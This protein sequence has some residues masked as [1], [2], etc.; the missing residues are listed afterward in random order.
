MSSEP[1]TGPDLVWF[2]NIPT[3]YRIPIWKRLASRLDFNLIFFAK[4]ERERNWDLEIPLQGLRHIYLNLKPIYLS[5]QIPIYFNFLK[6]II[7]IRSINGK[8]I[9]LDGWESPAF[10]VSAI[11]AKRKGM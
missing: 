3:P 7:A 8:A 10:F 5:S 4:S 11:Y 2:T 6:S 9:Y 1:K